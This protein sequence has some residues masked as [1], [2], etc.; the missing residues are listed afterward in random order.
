MCNTGEAEAPSA[1]QWRAALEHNEE[2]LAAAPEDEVLAEMLAL[3]V[4]SSLIKCRAPVAFCES[5][6]GCTVQMCGKAC[7]CQGRSPVQRTVCPGGGLRNT[8]T[9]AAWSTRLGASALCLT[10]PPPPA[11]LA[12]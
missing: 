7:A 9:Q 10:R 1:D 2:L 8:C 4:R 6:L 5:L 11:T 3:Q 12:L